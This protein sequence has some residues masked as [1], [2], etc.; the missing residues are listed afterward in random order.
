[1]YQFYRIFSHRGFPLCSTHQMGF[2]MPTRSGFKPTALMMAVRATPERQVRSASLSRCRST[3]RRLVQQLTPECPEDVE[4]FCRPD[5][6]HAKA[7]RSMWMQ[8]AVEMPTMRANAVRCQQT[9]TPG[10]PMAL[11]R[12]RRQTIGNAYGYAVRNARR[13]TI[14]DR[15]KRRRFSGYERIKFW[16]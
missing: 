5:P 14:R 6:D 2:R 1:M 4:G 15:R 16:M 11:P 3:P 8:A 12:Q 13:L 7:V 10:L 9:K